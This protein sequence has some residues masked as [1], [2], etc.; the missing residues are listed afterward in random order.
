MIAFTK[1]MTVEA[2]EGPGSVVEHELEFKEVSPGVIEGTLVGRGGGGR[3]IAGTLTGN[4][5]EFTVQGGHGPQSE[6]V[7]APVRPGGPG[8]PGGHSGPPKDA[9][10]FYM[11]YAGEIK[12]DGTVSGTMT[13][14]GRYDEPTV[15]PL[16]G[17]RLD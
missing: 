4:R 14:T 3:K 7:D 13:C 5:F 9:K 15:D 12:D 16:V 2:H 8:G 11:T 6:E 1:A 17:H 10:P